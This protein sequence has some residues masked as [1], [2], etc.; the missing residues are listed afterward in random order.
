MMSASAPAS[1]RRSRAEA[2]AAGSLP[3]IAVMSEYPAASASRERAS[4]I[5]EE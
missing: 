5:A 2:S 3:A 4:S 1:R